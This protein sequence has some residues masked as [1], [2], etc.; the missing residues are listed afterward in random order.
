MPQRDESFQSGSGTGDA[1]VG[2]TRKIIGK[3][4]N[5]EQSVDSQRWPNQLT[6]SI[7]KDSK[8]VMLRKRAA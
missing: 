4:Q 6:A 2:R 7:N 1:A 3:N 5:P 8:A